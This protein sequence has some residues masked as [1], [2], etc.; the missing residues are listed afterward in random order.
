[1]IC[2]TD[3]IRTYLDEFIKEDDG[4]SDI[5]SRVI[6]KDKEESKNALIYINKL[7]NELVRNQ[8]RDLNY[9]NIHIEGADESTI[10]H[11]SEFVCIKFF[12][13]GVDAEEVAS[14]ENDLLGKKITEQ[15]KMLTYRFRETPSYVSGKKVTLKAKRWAEE[16]ARITAIH[17]FYSDIL[18]RRNER[19]ASIQPR[20]II[21]VLHKE[22]RYLLNQFNANPYALFIDQIKKDSSYLLLNCDK[23][24]NDIDGIKT[25]NDDYLSDGIENIILIDCER[26]RISQS[27][28]WRELSEWSNTGKLTN[29]IVFSFSNGSFSFNRLKSRLDRIQTRYYSIPKFPSYQAYTILAEELRML[30]IPNQIRTPTINFFGEGHSTF[31]EDFKLEIGVYE[32]LYELKSIKMMNVYSLVINK[33]LKQI[34]LD[35]I[36]NFSE[37]PKIITNDTRESLR[38]LTVESI[39][40][41]KTSLNNTLDFIIQSPWPNYLSDKAVRVPSIIIPDGIRRHD[42]FMRALQVA[43]RITRH[44]KLLIWFDWNVASDDE[45]IILDYRD[46]G[47]FPFG[48]IPNI[49]ELEAKDASKI[50]CYFLKFFFKD[51]F[52]WAI[53]NYNSNLTKMLNNELRVK[54][55]DW[56]GLFDKCQSIKPEREESTIWDFE[57]LYESGNPSVNVKVKFTNSAKFRSYSA[58]ELFVVR[59]SMANKFRVYRI[60]DLIEDDHSDN[61]S[62]QMLDEL[63]S[64]LNI[65]EKIA[66]VKKEE[67]ELQLIRSNYS[68]DKN[69]KADRLWKILL[70]RRCHNNSIDAIYDEVRLYIETRRLKLVSKNT[71]NEHWINPDS[72]SLIPREK[73]V[74]Y[75]LC[76]YLGLPKSYFK[77]MLRLKNVEVQNSRR[78]SKQM[79]ALLS[80]LINCGCFD[81]NADILEILT[82]LKN[83]FL[84]DHDFDEI[85]FYEETLIEDLEAL[86]ELLKPYLNPIQVEKI[87]LSQV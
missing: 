51:K 13:L 70:R 56:T 52:D 32:G 80:D 86:V 5:Y 22:L 6:A 34:L 43:L 60:E 79:N 64:E 84:S 58:S 75:S 26:K 19:G 3:H 14:I 17:G 81:D 53:Y 20:T 9:I 31:W 36:F 23:S 25:L 44:N 66:N 82:P 29:L 54:Y 18:K 47:R 41:L 8:D 59:N 30:S 63:H 57:N 1:M 11:I 68:L 33:E 42:L 12:L 48:I 7:L 72:K 87:E 45:V 35:D 28:N 50:E 40:S 74:F 76:E 83:Q 49:V 27:F 46:V 73:K 24:R 69:E 15:I 77:I 67:E 62:I 21:N 38:E 65:Y 37:T 4:F 16:K 2:I 61:Y 71:F 55:F 39:S 10:H 85:G 78:N